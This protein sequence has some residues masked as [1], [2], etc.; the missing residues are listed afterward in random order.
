M[1][2]WVR[3]TPWRQGHVLPAE[4]IQALGLGVQGDDDS[5][6][7]VVIG[8]DCDLAQEPDVEPDVEVI[9]GRQVSAPDGNFTHGKNA[10]RLHLTFSGASDRITADLLAKSKRP[11]TK[12]DL[13]GYTPRRD[14]LLSPVERT[15]LQRWLAARYRRAAFPD[16]FERRLDHTGLRER[17]SKI[18]KT[19]GA[20]ISAV[21][22]DVDQ[23]EDVERSADSPDPY[24]LSIYL[25]FNTEF[26]P[27]GA[28]EA[29]MAA[30]SALIDVFQRRC[31]PDGAKW[32][33]FEL[34]ECE[35][36][37][38]QAM[39]VQQAD[40]FKRWSADY[41]SIRTNPPEAMRKDD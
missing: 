34:V 32:N 15:I 37:S 20:L 7:A 3:E 38:D 24:V 11:V 23:G 36:I 12:E 4:A 35:E 14:V 39:T 26:D 13:A 21:F 2:A 9:V 25:L 41:F 22:F 10:R 29:A 16:E 5:C 33:H 31:R 6:V 1:S 18:L 27:E 28:E 30:K 8:H 19:H 40:N 17:I